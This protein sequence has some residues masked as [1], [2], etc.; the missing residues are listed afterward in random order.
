MNHRSLPADASRS[1]RSVLVA[2]AT[3]GL[4][5]CPL[6]APAA[7]EMSA[8]DASTAA[9]LDRLQEAEMPD[10]TLWVL[11]RVSADPGAAAELKQEIPFRRASALVATTK[12]ESDSK[13]RAAIL[14]TAEQEIDRFLATGPEGRRAID[15]FSQKGNLLIQRGRAKVDQAK[16]PGED[17]KARSA[18]GSQS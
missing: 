3:F 17:A 8:R 16:R 18:A 2:F 13:K 1:I 4:A 15:A 10:V 12:T 5:A 7:E 6:A 11:E 9:L 14:D